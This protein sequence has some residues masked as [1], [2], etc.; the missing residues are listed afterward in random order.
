MKQLIKEM[1]KGIFPNS[2]I[3]KIVID[4]DGERD[5]KFS[6]DA[7]DLICE[8][9]A[10]RIACNMVKKSKPF[11]YPNNTIAYFSSYSATKM[12]IELENN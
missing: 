10:Y 3:K 9:Q 7:L 1:K 12:V 5:Y 8:Q 4:Y 6:G 11:C 2:M